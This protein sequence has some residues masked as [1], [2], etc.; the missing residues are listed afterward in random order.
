MFVA[1][2]YRVVDKNAV[3]TLAAFGAGGKGARRKRGR[4]SYRTDLSPLC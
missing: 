4:R 3:K 2:C 1:L